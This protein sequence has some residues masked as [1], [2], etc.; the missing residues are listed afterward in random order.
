MFAPYFL[1][2]YAVGQAIHVIGWRE[3]PD[4]LRTLKVE[5]IDRV[6]CCA[7]AMTYRR[8]FDPTELLADA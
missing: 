2:P 4:A 1:E 8:D 5:R 7:K 3:P 6:E